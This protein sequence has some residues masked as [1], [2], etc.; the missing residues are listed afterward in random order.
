MIDIND[1]MERKEKERQTTG[2][3][4]VLTQRDGWNEIGYA[5]T[6]GFR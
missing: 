1:I 2:S 3:G 6:C 5:Q 4:R